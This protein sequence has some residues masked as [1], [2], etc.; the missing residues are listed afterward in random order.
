[1]KFLV[2][3]NVNGDDHHHGSGRHTHQKCEI[4]YVDAPGNFV[5][6]TRHHQAMHELFG[7]CIEPEKAKSSEYSHPRVV[8]PIT[9]KRDARAAPKKG[10]VV[11]GG[12]DHGN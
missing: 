11:L 9:N 8:S 10:E 3:I 4:G 12:L 2:I 1:M 7:V 5:A 6:H